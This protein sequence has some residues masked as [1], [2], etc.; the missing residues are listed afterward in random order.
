MLTKPSWSLLQKCPCSMLI[1][2]GPT[3]ATELHDPA[4]NTIESAQI[5]KKCRGDML[6]IYYVYDSSE[7]PSFSMYQMM[8]VSFFL[9]IDEYQW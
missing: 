4:G 5:R 6:Y 1:D 3:E 8:R 2:C 7:S 9:P